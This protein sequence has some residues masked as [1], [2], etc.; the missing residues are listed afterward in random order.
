MKLRCPRCGHSA[1]L[2]DFANEEAARKAVL[3]A[4]DLPKSIGYLTLRYVGLFR[5]STRS[6]SW[7]RTLKLMQQL[8]VDIDRAR[9]ERHGRIWHAPEALWHE[10]FTVMLARA[11]S[12][13]LRLP[14]KNHAYLYEIISAKQNSAEARE[15]Q[16]LEEKRQQAQHRKQPVPTVKP[17]KD[18]AN[19]QAAE[20][21][22][23]SIRNNPK[24]RKTRNKP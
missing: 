14:L 20:M 8:K 23:Q 7:E 11:E 13:D 5:P 3:L 19:I 17:K 18:D 24:F 10:G 6:L 1:S 22:M 12:D 2:Q 4:A 16:K 21:T 15:E 9:I